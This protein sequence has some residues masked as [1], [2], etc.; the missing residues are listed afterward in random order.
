[1]G[2]SLVAVSLICSFAYLPFRLP[3]FPVKRTSTEQ[4]EEKICRSKDL[5]IEQYKKYEQLKGNFQKNLL[6]GEER[7]WMRCFRL[8]FEITLG[9]QPQ[10]HIVKS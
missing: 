7:V 3:A 10:S 5:P 4:I 9:F 6:T 8:S 1:M 2:G